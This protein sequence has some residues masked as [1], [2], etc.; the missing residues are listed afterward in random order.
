[1]IGPINGPQR[2]GRRYVEG[3]VD[4]LSAR[5]WAI[6]STLDR[7]RLATGTQL[8]RLHFSDL[9]VR[10]Q[11]AA[12]SRVLK[13]LADA[14]VVIQLE[15]RVGTA[16]RGS[17]PAC[18]ALDSA[19]QQLVRLSANLNN[20]TAR[21]RRSVTPGDRFMSHA[22]W[23]TE[24]YV[25]LAERARRGQFKLVDFKVDPAYPN[26]LGGWIRPDALVVLSKRDNFYWWYEADLGTESLATVRR[27]L[28]AYLDYFERGQLMPS[29]DVMPWV[30]IGVLTEQRRTGFLN[31]IDKLPAPAQDMF[32]VSLLKDVPAGMVELMA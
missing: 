27:K 4:S 2:V 29:G 14:R 25:A 30:D 5:D 10:G 17:S 13:R 31:L 22:L 24:L 9:S 21:V 11:V 7:V 15:R 3:L 23:V 26:G 8:Q 18:Y 32:L 16:R 19:G 20:P 1:M 28:F 12:R 6:V